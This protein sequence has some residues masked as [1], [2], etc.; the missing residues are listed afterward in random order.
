MR[1]K[2][3]EEIGLKF[4]KSIPRKQ[5]LAKAVLISRAFCFCSSPLFKFADLP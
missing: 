2:M 1:N 3:F 5:N 4:L